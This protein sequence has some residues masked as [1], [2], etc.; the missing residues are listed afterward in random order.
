MKNNIN[1]DELLKQSFLE[2]DPN[3]PTNDTLFDMASK[4]AFETEW[5][6]TSHKSV[7]PSTSIFNS[8][9]FYLSSVLLAGAITA[10]IYLNSDSST[11]NKVNI[12]KTAIK[13]NAALVTLP[14]N[15]LK[16]DL[17]EKKLMVKTPDYSFNTPAI[18]SIASGSSSAV[19][20][21]T[22][23]TMENKISFL[24]IT[25]DQEAESTPETKTN[26]KTFS[27]QEKVEIKSKINSLKLK[28]TS[29]LSDEIPMIPGAAGISNGKTFQ[30]AFY[31]WPTEITISE[32][33]L[34][35]NDLLLKGKNNEF[36]EYRP[37]LNNGFG[38]SLSDEDV[39][40]FHEYFSDPKFADNP[41]IFVSPEGA[42]AF[43][44]WIQGL[45]NEDKS[46]KDK[47]ATVRLPSKWEWERAAAGGKEHV[48]FG[49]FDGKLSTGL[50]HHTPEANFKEFQNKTF[51]FLT[52][53]KNK[54]EN[55][56]N[57]IFS[58]TTPVKT[59]K[60]NAYKLYD[61]S[62]NVSEMVVDVNGRII[63][64]G[65][66]WNSSKEFLK[67][68]DDDFNE[69]PKGALASPFI[70]FRPVINFN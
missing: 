41:V 66:N 59:F 58:F 31:M 61:M 7:T 16:K 28:L 14:S 65:G 3:N 17:E 63:V 8:W 57:K 52:S 23:E 22:P 39:K 13:N 54:K 67:I 44:K 37:N 55:S 60:A 56:S 70:G 48:E 36:E 50:L 68:H 35:L 10:G 51:S 24:S 9:K 42:D 49:T 47:F 46:E 4:N 45:I 26:F 21:Y 27:D 64:K 1:I 33:Q 69:F 34:F 25:K 43:C 12:P 2:L 62:G 53:E 38:S 19:V 40:F 29:G 32:Y 18:N 30:V 5:K 11:K 15:P 6:G 20:A